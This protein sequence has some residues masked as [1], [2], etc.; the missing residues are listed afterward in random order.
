MVDPWEANDTL[1][2]L[3]GKHTKEFTKKIPECV[4]VLKSIMRGQVIDDLCTCLES[5]QIM[6]KIVSF[7]IIDTFKTVKCIL[8]ADSAISEE[9]GPACIAEEVIK[10]YEFHAKNYMHMGI[11]RYL[12]DMLL[13][14]M[15]HFTFMHSGT[16]Y[17]K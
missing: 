15:K 3:K 17:L 16:M 5:F 1:Q 7:V 11:D 9:S 10:T 6:S 4:H 8:R 14:I 13:V 2:R 12:L